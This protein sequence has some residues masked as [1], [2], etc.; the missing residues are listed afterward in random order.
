[1]MF[2]FVCF[3]TAPESSTLEKCF[4]VSAALSAET[5]ILKKREE[6]PFKSEA[7]V[8]E[9]WMQNQSSKT[10]D[11]WSMH[12]PSKNLHYTAKIMLPW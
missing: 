6:K 3:N 7:K 11:K 2:D 12:S 9:T 1:M 4:S 8:M 5:N 10:E